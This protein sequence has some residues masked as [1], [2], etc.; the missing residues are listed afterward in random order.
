MVEALEHL[1]EASLPKDP[2]DL[3]TAL[4]ILE[5]IL[6]GRELAEDIDRL[7]TNGAAPSKDAL[8]VQQQQPQPSADPQADRIAALEALVAELRDP[9]KNPGGSKKQWVKAP[10]G[11]NNEILRW[12]PGMEP[13]RCK[14][15]QPG[16]AEAGGHLRRDCSTFPPPANKD[17]SGKQPQKPKEEPA[18]KDTA[19]VELSS[20][21]SDDDV[22]AKLNAAFGISGDPEE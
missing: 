8:A 20:D 1:A 6:R 16:D 5:D 11:P 18:P 19:V 15:K 21:M 13:C 2:E 4:G 3:E 22:I 10:R 9:K 14:K 7:T 17:R 12:I